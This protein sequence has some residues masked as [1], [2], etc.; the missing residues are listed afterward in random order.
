MLKKLLV[1][2]GLVLA[3]YASAATRSS[4][5]PAQAT[6]T[7]VPS[8]STSRL[9]LDKYCVTCHNEKSATAGI[10]LDSINP[11]QVAE[12][13]AV[14]EKVVHKLRTGSM[15][16]AGRPRPD[17]AG[18]N[19][20]IAHLE[21]EL[22]RASSANP[23]PGGPAIHRLNRA[24][25]TNAIRDLLAIEI[26]GES[27]LPVDETSDGFDN[28]S[29]VL[30]VT[31][32]LMERYMSAARKIS[33]AALGV[34]GQPISERYD[35]HKYAS[36]DDRMS[37][38]LPFGSRGGLA[39]HYYFP[40]DGEYTIRAFLQRN[41]RDY[42][43]GLT[44][45]HQ[46]DFRIDSVRI[47]LVTIGGMKGKSADIF[48][49]ASS[50]G[51]PE[52]EVYEHRG[53]EADLEARFSA[54]A[55]PHLVGVSFLK[56]NSVP[57]GVLQPR[58]TRFQ[59]VQY[60]G[61]E[62]AIDNIVISG[63]FNQTG[64]GDTPSRQK[65][66]VCRP[67]GAQD[68]EACARKILAT[69]AH[70][71]YRRPITEKDI[72][73]LLNMYAM[74]RNEGS[75]ESGLQAAL[76]RI[77]LSPEFLFRVERDP[78]NVA[79]DTVYRI[80]DL[81]LASRLSFFVWGSIPDDQ[82][83]E[84][85][86]SGKLKD[87]AILEQQVRRMLADPRS[88]S[89][90]TNFAEQWLY[91]QNIR[92]KTP[93]PKLFPDFD[94]NLREAFLQETELF[95]ES[96]LRE[97]QSV[98]NLLDADYTFLNERLAR[99]YGIPNVYGSHFRRVQ[100]GPEFDVRRGLMGQGSLLTVTSYA[101]R[102]SVVLRGKWLLENILGSPPSPPPPNVP[103][104]EESATE[105]KPLPLRQLM[106][107]HRKNAVCANCHAPMDPLGFALENFDAT[108]QWRTADADTPI[109]A[110]GILADG[111]QLDGPSGLR[112]VLRSRPEAFAGVV[113][114]RMLTYALG[115]KLDYYDVPAI[116][117]IVRDAAKENYRWSSFILAT[118]NSM[119]FQMR[120]S[121]NP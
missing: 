96:T 18:Y 25:Y 9:L 36:Q 76:E 11:D 6:G 55:G 121:Q 60:K 19:A 24:E 39:I 42:I 89:L 83:L 95:L 62:P 48:S 102:T 90:V 107:K 54:K 13:A 15:P 92:S 113:S 17:S 3:G 112:K 80:N 71:A 41:S 120:R 63:P 75:F 77:L 40:M 53:A 74:G 93:D 91:V 43:R 108:G 31:P 57:E 22:D 47:K 115:R 68:E 7:S 85:A 2:G 29:D 111:T 35:V 103:P 5:G 69:L 44:E 8:P 45:P 87:S 58:M 14:W 117:M 59:T 10:M 46:L 16:P 37:E 51:D 79:P 28:N 70:R 61:G 78:E 32:L 4:P 118:V 1:W 52:V 50:V 119:P 99:H 12:H 56:K 110:S 98:M 49:Q 100:L 84:L 27:L 101:N 21:D 109:D 82:L 23:N 97:D 106:E 67:T 33:A 20:L 64:T 105:G 38:D 114:D 116:R 73:I 94:E 81:E 34:E 26:D 72:R 88:K 30:S 65:I 86:E 66:F 104:L